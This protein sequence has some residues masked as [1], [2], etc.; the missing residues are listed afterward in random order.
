MARLGIA[1]EDRKAVLAHAEYDVHGR[2]YDR[3]ER[4]RE[5]RIALQVWERHVA[6]VLELTL[7]F[8][9]VT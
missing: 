5:K 7:S 3:Y 4:L 9:R 8:Q 2:V 6:Q 1:R